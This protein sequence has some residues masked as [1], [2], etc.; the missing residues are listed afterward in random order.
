MD[1]IFVCRGRI[2]SGGEWTERETLSNGKIVHRG[3]LVT[4][5]LY[6]FMANV[7]GYMISNPSYGI[8]GFIFLNGTQILDQMF[9]DDTM[10]FLKGNLDKFF[11]HFV[12]L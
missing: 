3:C 6:L 7:L 8:E 9:V 5:Y 10:L 2:I 12:K 1:N 11:R 4:P